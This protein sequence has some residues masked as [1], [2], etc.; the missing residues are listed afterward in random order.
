M[1]VIDLYRVTHGPAEVSGDK[2]MLTATGLIWI[3]ASQGG[4]ADHQPSPVVLSWSLVA[5]PPPRL[6]A[7][8]SREGDRMLLTV[9]GSDG[10]RVNLQRS[11]ALDGTR[12]WESIAILRLDG[13]PTQIDE[14]LDA[15]GSQYYRAIEVQ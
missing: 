11:T 8:I 10:V 9:H 12:A 3:E 2:L 6:S 4:D 1:C 14:E 15:T 5:P 13:T 7:S